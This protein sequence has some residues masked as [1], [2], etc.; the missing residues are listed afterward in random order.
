MALLHRR[1]VT[2]IRSTAP[3]Y[4]AC[5]WLLSHYI[6]ILGELRIIMLYKPISTFATS[7]RYSLHT[8]YESSLE[9]RIAKTPL[10]LSQF[11]LSIIPYISRA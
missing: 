10:L 5:S 11:D 7:V 4:E 8:N 6:E 3:E 9:V 1:A 2:G